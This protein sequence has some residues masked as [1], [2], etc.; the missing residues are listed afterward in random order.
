LAIGSS[1]VKETMKEN[2][3]IICARSPEN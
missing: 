1:R 3:M 2:Y